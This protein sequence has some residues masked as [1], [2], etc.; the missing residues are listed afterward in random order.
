[1]KILAGLSHKKLA[2]HLAKELNCQYV[3]TYIT[4]FDDSETKVQILEDV[5]GCD[6]VIVQSTSRP[7]NNHLMELLLLVDTV[8]RAGASK[9]TAVIPY[10]GYSRQDR[11]YDNFSPVPARLVANMLEIA[12]VDRI[13]T[14]DLHSQQLEGFFKIAIQNLEPISLFAP[15]I[16]NY[17]NAIIVSPDIGGFVRIGAVNK[18]FNM[19]MAVINKSRDSTDQCQM[20]EIIGNVSGKHCLL[21]DDIV[22]SGET[23]CKGAKLLMAVGALSVDAFVTHPVLS[24]LSKKNIENSDIMNIY[25]TDTIETTDLPSKFHIISVTPIIV[26]ALQPMQD[27]DKIM[28]I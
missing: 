28:R 25:I 12:G 24:G 3:E 4:T 9:V 17:N 10:L 27:Y 5:Q 18:L 20:S 2:R 23:L 13:I 21:I 14:V 1:M 19:N 8:K 6:V 7:T 26:A 11:R 15:I 16:K 22:D